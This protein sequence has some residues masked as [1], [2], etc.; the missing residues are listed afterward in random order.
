ML[1]QT[2]TPGLQ[3][4]YNPYLCPKILW[5]P[6]QPKQNLVHRRKEKTSHDYLIVTPKG[7]EFMGKG[8]DGMIIITPKEPSLLLHKPLLY[9]DKTTQ[10]TKPMFTGVVPH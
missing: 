6:K 7:I 2:L 10:G 8:E 4:G 3:S 9:P 1:N 5:V